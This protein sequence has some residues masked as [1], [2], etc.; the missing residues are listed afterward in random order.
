MVDPERLKADSII[1]NYDMSPDLAVIMTDDLLNERVADEQTNQRFVCVEINNNS[2]YANLCRY[3]ERVVFEQAFGN[4]S[5]E[6]KREYGPYDPA[7]RFFLSIDRTQKMP[8]GMIRIIQNSPEGLKT[9]NDV[10]EPPLNLRPEVVKDEH[11][12]DI[13]KTWDVGT[14]AVMPEFRSGEG[15]VSV[16]LYR[17]MYKSAC[18]HGIDHLVSVIDDRALTKL[19]DYLGIPFVPL[20]DSKP[21]SYLGSEKSQ[22]V[23]G[24]IPEF[25]AKMNRRRYTLKGFM[26]RRALGHLVQG[27]RDDA[28]FLS[29][30]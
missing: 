29:E 27:T 16:Q 11:S 1:P 9:L 3:V 6:L 20:A 23:Y 18:N 24:Y 19:T 26:A 28:L 22:A 5:E 7:S 8:T 15:A 4:D 2:K 12:L 17:A 13:N 21:F 30:E 25:Y 10:A 14:V